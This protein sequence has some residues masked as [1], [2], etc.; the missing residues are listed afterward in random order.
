MADRF[1]Q[2]DGFN[3]QQNVDLEDVAIIDNSKFIY[4]I[5]G[6]TLQL[7]L[8]NNVRMINE[9]RGTGNKFATLKHEAQAWADPKVI[10]SVHVPPGKLKI[11]QRKGE[12]IKKKLESRLSIN[13]DDISIDSFLR[14]SLPQPAQK[15]NKS[16][17][18]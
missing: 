4:G 11:K 15:R 1:D 10:H 5:D 2:E 13:S 8:P 17:K 16:K 12:K 14:E 7:D 6:E 9:L 3:K 18:L